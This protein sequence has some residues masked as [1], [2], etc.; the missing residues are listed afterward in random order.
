MFSC[1]LSPILSV[2]SPLLKYSEI[3]CPALT[4]LENET[5]VSKII[6]SMVSSLI[7]IQGQEEIPQIMFQLKENGLN[8]AIPPSS[9]WPAAQHVRRCSGCYI[10]GGFIFLMASEGK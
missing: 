5:E 4:Q 8:S 7:D 3:H 6:K 10:L 2:S 9:C 1:F